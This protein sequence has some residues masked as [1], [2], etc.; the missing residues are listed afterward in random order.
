M[1]IVFF[2]LT[3][4]SSW[5][6]GHATTYRALLRALASRGHDILFLECDKPWYADHRDL[7]DPGFCR[8][9]FYGDASDLERHRLAIAGADVVVIGSYVP[10][11]ASVIDLVSSWVRGTFC[12][13]DIDTPVTLRGVCDGSAEY[14]LASQIPLFDLYF[15]FTGGPTLRRLERQFGA[16]RARAL[17]C[18]VDTEE[19]Q[20]HT[21]TRR[22]ALG[23]LG[24]YSP[25]RQPALELLL[26]QAARRLPGERFVVA[27]PQYPRDID[28]PHNVDRIEHLPPAEHSAF[29]AAQEWT[30]NVTRTDM[31]LCGYSPSVRLFEATACGTAVMTDSWPGIETI[32]KPQEQI[33]VVHGVADLIATLALS[34]AERNRIASAGRRRTVQQHTA[35]A[36]AR[37]M[38]ACLATVRRVPL[39]VAIR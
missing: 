18:G 25:D 37:E 22:W 13:Y 16:R 24:T 36:R 15:S 33:V 5:G 23:Y 29:Y 39:R 14:L 6:N 28:W 27:G 35:E 4:S 20:P 19:Y 32:F 30:L 2:G 34:P 3:L 1:R 7:T 17:Y 31:A 9:A 11:G 8:L 26:L 38:E 12:F 21:V 10:D